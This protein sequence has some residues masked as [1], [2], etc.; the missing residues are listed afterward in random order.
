M[1]QSSNDRGQSQTLVENHDFCPSQNNNNNNNNFYSLGR[2]K[3]ILTDMYSAFRSE[4][5]E[6]LDAAQED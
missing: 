6:A 2:K 5:T 1:R 4:D 3:I